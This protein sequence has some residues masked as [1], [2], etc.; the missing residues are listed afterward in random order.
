MGFNKRVKIQLT[1]G[2]SA[3]AD[4]YTQQLMASAMADFLEAENPQPDDMLVFD[5]SFKDKEGVI[6]L[7]NP[8]RFV[9]EQVR[10]IKQA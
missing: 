10:R 4:V 3:A 9:R 6:H 7:L 1:A 5:F 2:V 8:Q